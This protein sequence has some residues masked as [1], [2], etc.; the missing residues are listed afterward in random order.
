M[1]KLEKI[2]HKL[3][4]FCKV[5]TGILNKLNL[6][7]HTF[8]KTFHKGS[9]I[10]IQNTACN[11]LDIILQGVVS[12]QSLELS[13]NSMTI[14]DFHKGEVLGSNL[15][16]SSY[17][18]Y[19]MT[20]FAKTKVE[21]YSFDRECVLFLCQNSTEFLQEFLNQLSDKTLILTGKIN[22][23]GLKSI[24]EKVIEFLQKECKKQGSAT[25]ELP[26][27]KKE[28]AE[29]LGVQ[30]PSLS[31]TLNKMQQEGIISFHNK[32]ITFKG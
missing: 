6:A 2:L 16:F 29:L 12:V 30:R 21:M 19:P 24:K 32:I 14:G 17:P 25:I 20:I 8:K 22:T 9:I 5:S 31:R 26:F 4:L 23:I 3:P 28:W 11:S 1:E 13:G 18:E 10:Y 7:N 27:S 15:L